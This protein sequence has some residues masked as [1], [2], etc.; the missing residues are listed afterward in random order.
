MLLLRWWIGPG[1]QGHFQAAQCC[2]VAIVLSAGRKQHAVVAGVEQQGAALRMG[3]AQQLHPL[4]QQGAA[5]V[6]A[7]VVGLVQRAV[8]QRRA[9]LWQRVAAVGVQHDQLAR[10]WV[11]QGG[12]QAVGEHFVQVAIA[13]FLVHRTGAAQRQ[14]EKIFS[15]AEKARIAKGKGLVA[16]VLRQ[17]DERRR[18]ALAA[19]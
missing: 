6:D 5:V 3:I 11:G 8:A 13:H 2:A 16:R 15:S 10:R 1:Q 7:V 14:A 18:A 17:V 19:L 4:R 12:A 9:L